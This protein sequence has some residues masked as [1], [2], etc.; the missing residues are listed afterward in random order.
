[1]EYAICGSKMV[2]FEMLRRHTEYKKP[3]KEHSD[4]VKFFWE[5]VNE[6]SEIERLKFIK[7]C[8]AQ[9]RL[10]ASDEEFDKKQIKLGLKPA[11]YAAAKK[12]PDKC[13][14]KA[15]TC[16]FNLELPNYSSKEILKKQLIIAISFDND[17]I[18]NDTDLN[19]NQG[20][21]R[22]ESYGEEE[23]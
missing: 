21:A 2:D 9:E 5:A 13:L 23:E 7:F 11:L 1:M 8:W 10:P 14:P 12:N 16:F 22:R 17:A 18:D 15:D 20:R 3:L 4:L 6:L 19:Q